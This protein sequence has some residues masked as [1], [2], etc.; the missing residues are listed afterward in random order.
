MSRF[1]VDTIP[2]ST[3]SRSLIRTGLYIIGS[4]LDAATAL[5][6]GTSSQSSAPNTIRSH[7]SR[8]V[9]ARYSSF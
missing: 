1:V 6:I 7:V 4:A 3:I 8:S 5:E 9:A 2:P